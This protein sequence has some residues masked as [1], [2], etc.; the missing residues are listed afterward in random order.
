MYSLRSAGMQTLPAVRTQ[1]LHTRNSQ[2]PS[3]GQKKAGIP[4]ESSYACVCFSVSGDH[5]YLEQNST[6]ENDTRHLF[7]YL[8]YT[9]IHLQ[10]KYGPVA[11]VMLV[12]DA[13][14]YWWFIY[15]E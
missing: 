6:Q 3:W 5:Q 10:M 11:F 8:E 15:K 12:L 7:F 13:S 1:P 14:C 4:C 2:A 9:E